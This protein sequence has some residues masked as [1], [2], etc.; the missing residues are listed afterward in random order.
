MPYIVYLGK[1]ITGSIN[2]VTIKYN[3]SLTTILRL[4]A[5]EVI[6]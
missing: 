5:I 6:I 3:F 4:G 1:K 2:D